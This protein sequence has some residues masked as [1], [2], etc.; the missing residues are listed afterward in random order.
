MRPGQAD[1][2]L[3]LDEGGRG[4]FLAPGPALPRTAPPW[5]SWPSTSR[6]RPTPLARKV[7]ICDPRLQAPDR[8]GRLPARGHH[9]RPQHLRRRHR[10]RGAQQLRRRLHRGDPR[11]SRRPC[12]TP[13][14]P[15][16]S[17]TSPSPSAATSR[18]A[19]RCTRSSSTTPSTPAWTWA[20]STPASC[21]S[22][23]RSSPELREAF[24]DVILNRRRDD[25]D[26]AAGR[27]SPSVQGRGGPRGQRA[28]PGLARLAG[29]RAARARPGQRHHR[30]HRRRHRGGPP[31]RRAPAARHRRP[32]DGRHERR[33]RPVRLGQDV[34]AAGGEVGPGD[35]AGRGLAPAL[36]GGR[37]G[38]KARRRARRAPA[39]S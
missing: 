4:G 34:P 18:C 22:T 19:R 16:A 2:Q 17:P 10:H 13:T 32:A 33:R 26:R 15:A 39:R 8:G 5:W 24:E 20:S 38:R 27:R 35:E 6:A 31:R 30:V 37:E 12:R 23:T 25:A 36:H 14:S 1:R 3:D 11:G 21:R 9:L 7:E 29:R 28:R